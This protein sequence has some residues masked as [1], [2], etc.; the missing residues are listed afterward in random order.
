M[1]VP[2]HPPP[3][4]PTSLDCGRGPSCTICLPLHAWWFRLHLSSSHPLK[5]NCI[6]MSRRPHVILILVAPTTMC[7]KQRMR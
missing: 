3:R 6:Q 1:E 2:P 4:I 7:S 5:A